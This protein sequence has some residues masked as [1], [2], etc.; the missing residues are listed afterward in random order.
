[1]ADKFEKELIE[2]Q[3]KRRKDRQQATTK[4]RRQGDA[5]PN[6]FASLLTQFFKADPEA[7]TQIEHSK[8]LDAWPRYVGDV[9]ARASKAARIRNGTLTV[10]VKDP[11]WMQE[12]SF[13]KR[14]L[15]AKYQAEFPKLGIRDIY[16]SRY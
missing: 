15:L 7:L 5:L 16:F 9:A 6:S 11:M 8:A 13:Q 1:V 10:V 3:K 12:L 14:N 2:L 4:R